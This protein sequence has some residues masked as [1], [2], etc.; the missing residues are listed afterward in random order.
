MWL[1]GAGVVARDGVGLRGWG[2]V[3]LLRLGGAGG[4][5]GVECVW[6]RRVGWDGIECGWIGRCNGMRSAEDGALAALAYGRKCLLF[7]RGDDH[8]PS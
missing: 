1:R 5:R 6:V 8:V 7:R 4:T 2:G 3:A